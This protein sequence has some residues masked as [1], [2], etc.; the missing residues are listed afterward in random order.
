MPGSGPTPNLPTG[1]IPDESWVN[2][3]WAVIFAF[4]PII[5]CFIMFFIVQAA[6][7]IWQR[8]RA[9]NDMQMELT[10]GH[11]KFTGERTAFSR[12][13]GTKAQDDLLRKL[14]D[15]EE[16]HVYLQATPRGIIAGSGPIPAKDVTSG[17]NG[18]PSSSP[19]GS[20][21]LSWIAKAMKMAFKSKTH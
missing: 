2:Q 11:C 6:W 8:H 21:W 19:A 17:A 16:G 20:L 14:R 10:L 3:V 1:N 5:V 13:L 12:F 18:A 7:A 15:L 4:G 9:C